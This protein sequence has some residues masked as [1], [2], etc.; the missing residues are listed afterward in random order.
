M[1]HLY[2]VQVA[3]RDPTRPAHQKILEEE[4]TQLDHAHDVLPICRRIVEIA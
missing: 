3:T 4:H 2:M 1:S